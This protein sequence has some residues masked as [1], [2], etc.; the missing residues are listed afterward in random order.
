MH[1]FEEPK[2]DCHNHVLDPAR[3]PYGIDNPYRPAG[4]EIGTAAQLL[5]VMESHSVRHSLVVAPNSGYGT[6]LRC[7]LDAIEHAEGRLKGIAVVPLD[8]GVP[9]LRTLKAQGVIGVAF[10][11]TFD[12][13][14][15]YANGRELVTK[16]ADLDMFLQ[17]QVEHDQILALLPV[18]H[19]APVRLLIDHC[20]RPTPAAGLAQ[21]GFQAIL[22]LAATGRASVKLSGLMK[23]SREPYPYADT[24]PFVRALAGAFGLDACVWGS[25]WPF[26]RAPERLDYGPLLSLTAQLFPAPSD[27]QKLFWDTPR[28][29]FG[30]AAA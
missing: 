2:I 24:W 4:Q 9:A 14:A 28:R 26:L 10:N 21:P 12:G 27:R 15:R 22:A 13:V 29:L 1:V 19:A 11:P 7:L 5:R 20:G 25:D 30:F 6:D 8:I 18:I 23:F 3:F 16:L 17:V